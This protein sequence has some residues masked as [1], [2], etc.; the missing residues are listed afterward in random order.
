MWPEIE[1]AKQSNKRELILDGD[2][3]TKQIENTGG[4]DESLFEL[5]DLNFLR[6]SQTCLQSL[7][8]KIQQLSGKLT[9]LVL[10]KNRLTELPDEVGKLSHLKLLDLSGN[11]LGSLNPS[12]CQ[13]TELLTLNLCQNELEALPDLAGLTNLH[14]LLLTS[15]KLTSLPVGLAG[16]EHLAT[17]QAD[18]NQ[19]ALL[20]EDIDRISMLKVLNMADNALTELPPGLVTL[21]KLK[22]LDLRGN[23]F[24]DRRL[25]KLANVDQTQPKGVF[26]FLKP[27]Y[28]KQK[29]S[30]GLMFS[31]NLLSVLC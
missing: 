26:K 15:N 2:V 8:P 10:N 30:G 12:V 6:I 4:I 16:L 23:K 18:H 11:A 27:L 28:D 13:L 5:V 24:S 1:A 25:L 22:V 19:L 7:H 9:S 20:P 21:D 3:I 14:E 31:L 29:S 17:I